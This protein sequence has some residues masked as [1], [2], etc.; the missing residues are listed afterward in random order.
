MVSAFTCYK[1]RSCDLFCRNGNL[2]TKEQEKYYLEL[3][4]KRADR[5]S[6]Q[7]LTGEQEFMGS[8]LFQVNEHDEYRL[9]RYR[10]PCRRSVK[11]RVSG[12]VKI[13]CVLD[14]GVFC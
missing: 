1:N 2:L 13:P 9:S 8:H 7:H 6:L 14:Q 3:I 10:N 12:Y 4:R 5:I 11:D